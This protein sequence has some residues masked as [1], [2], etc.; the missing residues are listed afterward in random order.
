LADGN[1]HEA[2]HNFSCQKLPAQEDENDDAQDAYFNDQIG[3]GFN[4]QIGEGEHEGNPGDEMRTF[5]DQ[6][7]SRSQCRRGARGADSPESGGQTAAFGI[8][9]TQVWRE[10]ALGHK[11]LYHG[12]DKVSQHESPA[13]FPKKPADVLA[14]SPNETQNLLKN[15]MLIPHFFD[16]IVVWRSEKD[17][18][19]NKL[20]HE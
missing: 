6:R 7:S 15:K 19:F 20:L 2:S 1:Q 10:P 8:R 17:F 12:A 18:Y 13:G 16:S 4:D 14:A 9:T 11:R 5:H 3:G